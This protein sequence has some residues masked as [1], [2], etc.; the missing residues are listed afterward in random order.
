MADLVNGGPKEMPALAIGWDAEHQT[1]ELQFDPIQFK[2]WDFV[3]VLSAAPDDKVRDGRR[4][5]LMRN[6]QEQQAA[7][8]QGQALLHNLRR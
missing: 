3:L 2:T 8:M 6:M 7:A 4:A 1:V 5:A